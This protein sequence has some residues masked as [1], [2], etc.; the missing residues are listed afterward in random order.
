MLGHAVLAMLGKPARVADL[1]AGLGTFAFA[2]VKKSFV[3]AVEGDG[4]SVKALADAALRARLADRVTVEQRD[5]ARMPLAPHELAAF[6]AVIFDPPRAG[7]MSQSRALAGSSVKT[8]VAVSCNPA[9]FARDARI[10]VDGGYRLGPVQPVDSF[11]WSAQLEL[12][13]RFERG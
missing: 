6:D 13:A 11:L 4:A 10:L 1:Y 9:T 5:L 12:V 8:I 7:A 2:A 3:H